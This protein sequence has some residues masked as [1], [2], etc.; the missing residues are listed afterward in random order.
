MLNPPVHGKVKSDFFLAQD[1]YLEP[2]GAI[3]RSQIIMLSPQVPSRAR[4]SLQNLKSRTKC[5]GLY[6]IC[7]VT[8]SSYNASIC[9]TREV[10]G[11]I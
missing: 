11:T 4:H 6:L 2:M 1:F 8:F 7:L 10:T 9:A 5:Q 3:P